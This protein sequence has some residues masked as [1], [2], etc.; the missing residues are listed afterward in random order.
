MS[1]GDSVILDGDLA[2]TRLRVI[3]SDIASVSSDE[4]VKVT[5]NDTTAGFLL[6]KV[7]AGTGITLTEL[8]DG[9]DEDLEIAVTGGTTGSWE[10][11][12]TQV[13]TTDATV[14]F[15]GFIDAAFN[16]YILVGSN[17]TFTGGSGTDVHLLTSTDGGS[18]Y[19]TGVADYRYGTTGIDAAGVIRSFNGNGVAQIIIAQDLDTG[20]RKLSFNLELFNPTDTDRTHFM[21]DSV[22]TLTTNSRIMRLS[23]SGER[24]ALSDVDAF[25]L[26][27]STGNISG[28]FSLY[29]IFK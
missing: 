15:T 2:N 4:L 27:G 23:G 13:I 18:S 9:G 17:V 16:N 28:D 29:G 1:Q 3:A 8:N 6:A 21:I 20:T 22:Y 11:L 7:V 26:L 25:R 19:D 24:A 12:E 10:L 14:D 5:A